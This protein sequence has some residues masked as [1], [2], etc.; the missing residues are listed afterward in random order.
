ML[1]AAFLMIVMIIIASIIPDINN[2]IANADPPINISPNSI[3]INN[4]TKPIVKIANNVIIINSSYKL[5]YTL[6]YR[7]RIIRDY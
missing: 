7:R 4:P 5:V 2:G 1:L 6:H 3:A